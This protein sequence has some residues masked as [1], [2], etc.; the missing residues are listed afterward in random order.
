MH[1]QSMTRHVCRLHMQCHAMYIHAC[2]PHAYCMQYMHAL[3]RY[4]GFLKKFTDKAAAYICMHG[5]AYY[6]QA[7][8]RAA[9]WPA[10]VS[11]QA[12]SIS[13]HMLN[14]CVHDVKV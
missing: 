4:Y 11:Q 3:E 2:M 1:V 5:R 14:M 7:Q 8:G 6:A 12:L 10:L 13:V 9:D